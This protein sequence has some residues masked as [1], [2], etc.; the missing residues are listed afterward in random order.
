MKQYKNLK[1][2]VIEPALEE[3][4]KNF[5]GLKEINLKE[6]KKGRKVVSLEIEFK[7]KFQLIKND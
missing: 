3:Y 5:K 4:K 1:R 7:G 6:I 2:R